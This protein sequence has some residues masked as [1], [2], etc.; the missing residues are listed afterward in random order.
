MNVLF[1]TQGRTLRLFDDTARAMRS[2]GAVSGVGFYVTDSAYYDT[3]L[4]S[5]PDFADDDRVLKEWEL[6][7][8]AATRCPDPARLADYE[9]QLGDPVLWN[10]IVADRRLYLGAIAVREQDYAARFSHEALLAILQTLIEELNALF[11]RVQP[12]MVVGFIC[13]TAA[14]YLAS[15]IARARGI[16]FLD[17]RPTRLRNYFFAGESVQEPSAL[18][19]ALYRSYRDRGIPAEMRAAADEI[20]AAIRNQHAM[21]EGVLPTPGN[22]VT[23]PP[24]APAAARSTPVKRLA[25]ILR[26]TRY[27]RL[28]PGRHDTHHQ[29]RLAAHWFRRVRRPLRLRRIER[30]LRPAYATASTLCELDYAFFPL[31]K[32]PEVTLLVYGR[33]FLNQIE[34]VRHIARSLPVGMKLVVKEHPGAIGYRPLGYYRKLLAIPN[35]VLA[36][37]ELTSRAVLEHAKLVTVIGGSIGL[38]AAVLGRPTLAFG[39]VPFA[40]LPET[41]LR[42]AGAPDAL[43]DEILTLLTDYRHDEDAIIAYVA[44]VVA[45]SVPVDFYSVLIGRSGV[46][47]PDGAGAEEYRAQIARLGDYLLRCASA[48]RNDKTASLAATGT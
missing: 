24:K 22:A 42:T 18:V 15:L 23:A 14:E 11:D 35:V 10:A 26:E 16:P 31:H 30:A 40:F 44:A 17:L 33:P 27:Y 36:A 4:G 9:R 38:E 13:V 19:G 41:M 20:L 46:Y 5:R 45:S 1:L 8:R 25:R 39:R 28:G 47:R 34:V 6:L 21:Y 7:A 2:D 32:E 29:T 3:Y 37:P 48:R 12:N 43:A